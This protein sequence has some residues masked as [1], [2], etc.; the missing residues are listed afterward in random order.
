MLF[1]CPTLP[2][3]YVMTDVYPPRGLTYIKSLDGLRAM[4]ALMVVFFHSP[5]RLFSFQF[6]W[7]GVNLFFI[8][9]GFLI[10]RILLNS[11]A[12]S[13][14]RYSLYFYSRR[15][16]R[17]FPLYFFYI[18]LAVAL[19]FWL[20]RTMIVPGPEIAQGIHD[21]R[22]NYPYLVTYTYNFQQVINF[23]HHR[24]YS[25]SLAFGHLWSL[26]V[27]EQFYL[28]FPFIVYFVPVK[29]LKKILAVIVILVPFL[30]LLFVIWMKQKTSDLFWIGDVLY[31]LTPFQLDALSLGA[32]IALFDFGAIVKRWKVWLWVVAGL[33]VIT[34]IVHLLVLPTYNVRIE[35]SSLGF[36]NPVYHLVNP[37][38]NFILNNRYLYTIPLLNLFFGLLVLAAVNGKLW[39]GFFENRI[40]VQIGKISY[41]IYIYHL[42]FSYLFREMAFRIFGDLNSGNIFIQGLMMITYLALLF[43][44]ASISFYYFERKFLRL[45]KKFSASP[46]Q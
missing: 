2:G 30:R 4:A 27:E 17:I 41:G 14:S 5:G 13:F 3:Q 12:L 38:E 28:V 24:D 43:G 7:A 6:G 22:S 20:N 9:S 19:L 39:A 25:S 34:G 35:N 29:W 23:L 42:F 31:I 46:I 8:L 36:D 15:S 40:L 45:K 16:L 37:I 33:L 10:T 44:I 11:K 26:S 32:C 1:I 18:L 21:F